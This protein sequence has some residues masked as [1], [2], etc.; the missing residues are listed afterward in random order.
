MGL[1]SEGL[2]FGGA[3]IRR[4]LFSEGNLCMS[5]I[6]RCA[7]DNIGA[8]TRNSWQL[9]LSE[10]S[11]FKHNSNKLYWKWNTVHKCHSFRVNFDTCRRRRD[12]RGSPRHDVSY[13]FIAWFVTPP[14]PPPVSHPGPVT[15]HV[16]HPKANFHTSL[17]QPHTR[18]NNW[19]NGLARQFSQMFPLV[20][21][22]L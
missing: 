5:A 8:L 2:I 3:Y 1:Y 21:S 18:G 10:H 13:A 14:P 17:S 19:A 15:V 22:G 6:F 11:N 7:N 20:C 16:M 4:G 9:N 12:R